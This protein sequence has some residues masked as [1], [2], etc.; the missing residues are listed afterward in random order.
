MIY[1]KFL[2]A[3]ALSAGFVDVALARGGQGRGGQNGNQGQNQGGSN[4]TAAGTPTTGDNAQD[5]LN[6]ANVQTG[7]AS[8]GQGQV[9]GVAAGQAPSET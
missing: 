3:L 9:S 1:G 4:G 8:D 6:P 7:S 2:V 5:V